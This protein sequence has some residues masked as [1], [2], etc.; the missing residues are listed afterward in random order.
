MS[1][2]GNSQPLAAIVILNYRC[3]DMTIECVRSVR[4][5]NR[6]DLHIFVVDN[7]SGDD[8]VAKLEN[9]LTHKNETLI[10]SCRNGGFSD[11]SNLGIIQ[12]LELGARWIHLLNP[13]TEVDPKF[14]DALEE[15]QTN[16]PD[17][18]AVGGLGLFMNERDKI[19]FAG[20]YFDWWR[21]RGEC[22]KQGQKLSDVDVS[23]LEG[24]SEFLTCACLV[25][26]ADVVETIGLLDTRYFLGGEEWDYSRR[27]AKAGYRRHF[28][29]N[30]RYWHHVS[31]SLE[32]KRSIKYIYNGY[33]T[34]LLFMR[35]QW[36]VLNVFWKIFYR[37]YSSFVATR[38]FRRLDASLDP[39]AI[40]QA[41]KDA[42]QD[43][44]KYASIQLSHL[45]AY[46]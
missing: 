42:E 26:R 18:A 29:P 25:V 4:A 31:G 12:G 37:L 34:K 30:M 19:W 23:A 38:N 15:L 33:R 8:S 44:R 36:P 43:D 39:H 35:D 13:D 14:Y 5:C 1:S 22:A 6:S 17:I 7:A 32:Q 24:S 40:G 41:I 21:G 11:G 9:E 16:S 2:Q 46:R 27:L 10:A 45:E 3:A 20:G 28:A